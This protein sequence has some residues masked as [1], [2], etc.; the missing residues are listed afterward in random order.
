MKTHERKLNFSN[1]NDNVSNKVLRP[2]DE[3]IVLISKLPLEI[4]YRPLELSADKKLQLQF[5]S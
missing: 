3:N 1:D 4:H 5:Y 2:F